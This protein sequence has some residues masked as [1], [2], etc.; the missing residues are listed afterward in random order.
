MI[1]NEQRMHIM[2]EFLKDYTAKHTGS[3]IAQKQGL[4]QKSVANVLLELEEFG[5]LLSEE[6]GKN[7]LYFLNL[8]DL[9]LVAS[10]LITVEY[11][12]T[13]FFYKKYPLIK[14]VL[15]KVKP[16]CKGSII[17]FGSYAKEREKKDSD[18]DLFVIGKADEKEIAKI[19]EAY[20]IE[21]NV[22]QCSL[23][24]FKELFKTDSLLKE[25]MKNHVFIKNGEEIISVE[26]E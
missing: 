4:N 23:P 16:H 6:S 12:R 3:S 9:E 17:I 24:D 13:L 15:T 11:L 8:N 1:L 18:L 26:L 20:A 5:I 21:I 19:Q 14:E 7:K 2:E 10:F 25:V 22:K